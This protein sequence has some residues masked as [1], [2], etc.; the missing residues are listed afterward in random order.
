M[1]KYFP[2][3]LLSDIFSRLPVK[4]I[5]RFKCVSKKFCSTIND[6]DFVKLHSSQSLKNKTNFKLVITDGDGHIILLRF[7]SLEDPEFLEN[8]LKYKTRDFVYP[9]AVCNGIVC[10]IR[11]DNTVAL[12]NIATRNHRILPS[13]DDESFSF[14][15]F[16]YDPSNDDYKVVRV[17]AP[18]VMVYSLKGNAWRK[19]NKDFHYPINS[20]HTSAPCFSGNV[21]VL[22]AP[23]QGIREDNLILRFDLSTE[24]FEEKLGENIWMMK[25]Y[26][27]KE[28]W[29]K[30]LSVVEQEGIRQMDY[31]LVLPVAYSLNREKVLLRLTGSREKCTKLA[32]YD[33]KK[34]RIEM[35]GKLKDTL[36]RDFFA[37]VTVESLVSLEERKQQLILYDQDN[38][39]GWDGRGLITA[40]RIF[41]VLVIALLA[42]CFIS[43]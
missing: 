31:S 29:T 20:V 2:P 23:V 12:F 9:I 33:L 3:E 6:I 34:K 30:L 39:Y 40:M 35:L 41:I 25:E 21:H 27:I 10:L 19:L 5:L 22:L 32:W 15:V 18:E 26:G 42:L 37:N 1:E 4:S 13:L 28:S 8:P 36:P 7:D 11:L 43:S 17:T 38:H 16:G 14:Q 24:E